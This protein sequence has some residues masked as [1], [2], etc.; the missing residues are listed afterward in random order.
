MKKLIAFFE[1]PA[2]PIFI[3]LSIFMKQC[4]GMQLPTFECEDG[5]NGLFHRRR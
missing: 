2:V 1:I 4:L 3:G 5:E